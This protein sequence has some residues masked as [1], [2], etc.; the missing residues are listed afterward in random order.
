MRKG[1]MCAGA[2]VL[3][4]S[5]TAE[6]T[7]MATGQDD[8][9]GGWDKVHGE[10][11]TVTLYRAKAHVE[12]VI[13]QRGSGLGGRLAPQYAVALDIP[14]DMSNFAQAPGC[15]N[16]RIVWIRSGQDVYD[17]G[18]DDEDELRFKY[19]RYEDMARELLDQAKLAYA[20]GRRVAVVVNPRH[21]STAVSG[22]KRP[23]VVRLAV[24]TTPEQASANVGAE[25]E[26]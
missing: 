14:L 21:T 22:C 2:L 10:V 5:A 13:V 19:V 16:N 26:R 3:A 4:G 11:D 17:K 15:G 12:R 9:S 8:A 7:L 20:T 24:E 23:E 25:V 6:W 18:G 1:L